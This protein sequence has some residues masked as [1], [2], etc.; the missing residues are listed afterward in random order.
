MGHRQ[1]PKEPKAKAAS[2]EDGLHH[3]AKCIKKPH[4]GEGKMHQWHKACRGAKG[5]GNEDRTTDGE[6]P[7]ALEGDERLAKEE[8]AK[9]LEEL[10]NLDSKS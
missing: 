3:D 6:H 8:S 10:R 5:R 9:L 4:R 7:R 2:A 1:T